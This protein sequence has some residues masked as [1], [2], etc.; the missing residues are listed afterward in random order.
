MNKGTPDVGKSKQRNSIIEKRLQFRAVEATDAFG[1]NDVW[2]ENGIARK[3][4]PGNTFIAFA[5]DRFR[6]QCTSATT[7]TNTAVKDNFFKAFVTDEAFLRTVDRL[8]AVKAVTRKNEIQQM[9]EER[10]ECKAL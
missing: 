6:H 1:N 8:F 2:F 4:C 3:P 9:V 5:S 10:H 7:A